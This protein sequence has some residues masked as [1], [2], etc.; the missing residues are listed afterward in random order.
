MAKIEVMPYLT[1]LEDVVGVAHGLDDSEKSQVVGVLRALARRVR[2]SKQPWREHI[3]AL[4]VARFAFVAELPDRIAERMPICVSVEDGKILAYITDSERSVFPLEET[5]VRLMPMNL[6]GLVQTIEGFRHEKW[7][8]D[9]FLAAGLLADAQ[10]HLLDE[11]SRLA[12]DIL[13]LVARCLYG[14]TPTEPA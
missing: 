9:E 1:W 3:F 12:T 6:L 14:M 11:E 5:S 7:L 4:A 2:R 10:I 13:R 8:T